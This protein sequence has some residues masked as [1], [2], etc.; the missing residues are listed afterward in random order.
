M[1]AC[2]PVLGRLL[3]AASRAVKVVAMPVRQDGTAPREYGSSGPTF[4]NRIQAD[5]A[6]ILSVAW[7]ASCAPAVAPYCCSVR[8][9]AGGVR[10]TIY[11]LWLADSPGEI[12]QL[13]A[14]REAAAQL[15]ASLPHAQ[16]K[17]KPWGPL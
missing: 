12:D 13:L 6:A 11:R 14:Q 1:E 5:P 16:R 4:A 8:V 7:E 10:Q 17:K 2:G 15:R 3:V 9:K